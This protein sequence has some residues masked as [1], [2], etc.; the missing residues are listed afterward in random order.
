MSRDR[1][2]I[3]GYLGLAEGKEGGELL[4]MNMAFLYR[5]TKMF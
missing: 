4:L 2:E 5:M 1:K 3:S